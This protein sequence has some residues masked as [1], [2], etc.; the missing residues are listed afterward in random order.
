MAKRRKNEL[1]GDNGSGKST[2]LH[3]L[4]G[5]EKSCIGKLMIGGKTYS[6]KSLT[7]ICYMVMQDVNHQLFTTSVLKEVL[8]SMKRPDEEKA[9]EIIEGWT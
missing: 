9:L 7:K 1:I 5:L 4:C 2:F 3:C 6:G 8:L